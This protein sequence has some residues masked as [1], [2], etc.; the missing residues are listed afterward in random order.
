MREALNKYSLNLKI[1]F[2][3]ALNFIILW[4]FLVKYLETQD[5]IVFNLNIDQCC[6]Y[7]Y[8]IILCS[9]VVLMVYF[10]D[11]YFVFIMT[12]FK[13]GVVIDNFHYYKKDN[14]FTLVYFLLSLFFFIS[15]L[16]L[17]LFNE[18]EDEFER[19]ERDQLDRAYKNQLFLSKD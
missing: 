13:A 8:F 17:K 10:K 19:K 7:I 2:I 14:K 9:E 12:L 11:V 18:N 3:L 15:Y 6:I 1:S 5:V 16:I 4:I